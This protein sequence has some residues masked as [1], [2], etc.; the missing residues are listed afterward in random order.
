MIVDSLGRS[1]KTLRISLTSQCNFACTYCVSP[2]QK[3]AVDKN[4]GAV[5]SAAELLS[6][7]GSLN[8]TLS[9]DTI[10][11]TGGEPLLY[12][13]LPA[14]IQGLL[15]MGIKNIKLTTNGYLLEQ[16]LSALVDA[17]LTSINVS[18]DALEEDVFYRMTRLKDISKVLSGIEKAVGSGLEVKIN[19]VIMKNENENQI[20]PLFEYASKLNIPIR[21]LELMKMGPLYNNYLDKFVSEEEVLNI[22]ASKYSFEKID[23]KASSTASYWKVKNG[24]DFGII[25]NESNPFCHDCNRLRLDSF[26]NI[27]GCISS[28]VGINIKENNKDELHKNLQLAMAQKQQK[29]SGSEM[30][31]KYIGG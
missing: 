19:S 23:R 11:L 18:L 20:L 14:L 24:S 26:G 16:R 29:F 7:V 27:Y 21:F 22:I 8:E 5:L 1:F 9:L 17:G 4:A 2:L 12:K 6:I 25:A 30:S 31:M 13:E 15:S 28:N 10:R 3:T